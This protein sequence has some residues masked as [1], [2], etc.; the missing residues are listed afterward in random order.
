V[1]AD[2]AG[3]ATS[4]AAAGSVDAVVWAPARP[5]AP[6]GAGWDQRLAG[7]ASGPEGDG[8]DTWKRVL[9]E[10][11]GITDGI[12]ADAAWARAVADHAAADGRP[13]RLVTLTDATT[14][15]GRSRAQAVAQH[16]RAARRATGEGVIACAV[17]VESTEAADLASAAELAAH[18]LATDDGPAL[19]GAEL[20]VGPGWV[21]LRGHPRPTASFTLGGRGIPSWFDEALR[22]VIG[23]PEGHR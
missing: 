21:G 23:A 15:G 8:D 6:D 1:A 14:A 11:S 5:P 9:A 3:A 7:T 2:F 22:D 16:A 20:V 13:I 17:G 12:H 19:S 18:L 10:H 4:L